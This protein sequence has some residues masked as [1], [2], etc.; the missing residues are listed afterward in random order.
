PVLERDP[1]RRQPRQ[2][3]VDGNL[4]RAIE[5]TQQTVLYLALGLEYSEYL[6]FRN[7]AGEVIFMVGG[8]ASHYG[9]KEPMLTDEAEFAVAYSADAVVQIETRVGSL[10]KPF[11][12]YFWNFWPGDRASA[13]TSGPSNYYPTP[14]LT[15]PE[16][17][18]YRSRSFVS[19]GGWTS[20]MPE[21]LA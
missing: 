6:R 3:T 8:S 1:R 10:E 11:G 4:T 7:I 20:G 13:A 9:M 14:S 19:G 5:R 21:S 16:S 2:A 17:R 12:R 15:G 18:P